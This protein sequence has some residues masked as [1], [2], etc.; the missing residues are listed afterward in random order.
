M[1]VKFRYVKHWKVIKDYLRIIFQRKIAEQ[2]FSSNY[3][4][5]KSL[6]TGVS[7]NDMFLFNFNFSAVTLMILPIA[8]AVTETL[9]P[10]PPTS[11]SKR[12]S[13]AF[14]G[15]E[16]EPDRSRRTSVHSRRR[17]STVSISPFSHE[18]LIAAMEERAA[19]K[20]AE[21]NE[22][23]AFLDETIQEAEISLKVPVLAESTT[24]LAPEEK[25]RGLTTAF[26]L[27]IAYGANIGGMVRHI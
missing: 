21:I 16:I 19:E 15:F 11:Q 5:K 7:T 17:Q 27:S 12:G 25:S 20:T 3:V 1:D 9:L 14:Q 26:N 22:A 24:M 8:V 6:S 2:N 18:M 13:V 23:T 4:E 10:P